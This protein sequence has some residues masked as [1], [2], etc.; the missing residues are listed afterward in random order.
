MAEINE[1]C[2]FTTI[3]HFV[4]RKIDAKSALEATKEELCLFALAA[5][6]L[7]KKVIITRCVFHYRVDLQILC[8]SFWPTN[9]SST[10]TKFAD[11]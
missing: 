8:K 1:G 4:F 9:P 2:R 10:Q 6:T 11:T 5:S 3:Q 7:N